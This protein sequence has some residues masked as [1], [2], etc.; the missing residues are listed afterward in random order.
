MPVLTYSDLVILFAAGVGLSG[1]GIIHLLLGRTPRLVRLGAGLAVAGAAGVAP[2]ALG[3]PGAAGIPAVIVAGVALAVALAGSG[4][5]QTLVQAGCRAAQRPAVRA[6]ALLVLGAAVAIGAAVQVESQDEALAD[7][8]TAWMMTIEAP[9][10][11]RPVAGNYAI[12]DCGWTVALGEP[13]APR[14]AEGRLQNDRRLLADLGFAERVIRVGPPADDSNCHGWVFTG[15]K[16]WVS[17]DEVENIL[18]DNGYQPISLPAA[19][20]LAVYRTPAGVVSHTA[21]VRAAGDGKPVLVE[22]KWGSIGVFLHPIDTSPYGKNVT[23]YRTPRGSHLLA[24]L[25]GPEPQP[26]NLTAE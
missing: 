11:L 15:G 12:T 2:V 3:H 6:A 21:V 26:F 4:K 14:P 23:Y 25:G 8:D 19:G 24:G 13:E 16:H 10:P 18:S 17:E 1:L 22:S 9:P 7:Q 20:D 5:F